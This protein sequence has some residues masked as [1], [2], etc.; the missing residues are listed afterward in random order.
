MT[1]AGQSTKATPEQQAAAE[2]AKVPVVKDRQNG[3]TRPNEGTKTGQVWDI[4]DRLSA[5]LEEP[6]G[7]AAVLAEADKAEINPDTAATQ[8]G[9]WRKYYGLKGRNTRKKNSS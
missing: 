3:V 2:A 5:E 1:T 8:F 6:A 4:A 7:R 9:R